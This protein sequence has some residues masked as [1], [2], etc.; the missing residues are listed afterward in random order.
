[1]D[2][3]LQLADELDD[4]QNRCSLAVQSRPEAV[5]VWQHAQRRLRLPRQPLHESFSS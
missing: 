5:V 2:T 4:T 3:L 1:M